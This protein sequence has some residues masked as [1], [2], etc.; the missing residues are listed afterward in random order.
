VKRRAWRG[1]LTLV[2][3]GIALTALALT[4]GSERHATTA[5]EL[6]IERDAPQQQDAER[7][8]ER[9][10]AAQVVAPATLGP[11]WIDLA[12]AAV[13]GS[14]LT[15]LI[16]AVVFFGRASLVAPAASGSA[17][18]AKDTVVQKKKG[19]GSISA[20]IANFDGICLPFGPPCAEGS[21]C[22][23]LPPDTNGDVG[24][25]QFVQMVNTDFAVY[26]KTGQ[27]LRHATPINELWSGV[28]G[29][30]FAHN[31]GDPVVVYDQFANR[32]LLSQFIVANSGEQYGQ[33]VAVSE[34]G[35]A[36]GKYFLYEFL[37]SPNVFLDYPKIG[38]WRDGYYMS[39]NEFPDGQVT[40]AG[41]AAIVFERSQM[42]NGQPA[43]FVYFDEAA[44]SYRPRA[45]RT[46]SPRSTIQRAFHP[47]DR[48]AASTCGSGGST[49][50]GRIR[51][52][53]RSG[54]TASRASRSR[55]RPSCGRS[56]STATAT[57]RSRRA[58]RR[59]STCSATA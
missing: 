47:P 7:T 42:L 53:R 5:H 40:S 48:T 23:C 41:A 45:S 10:R 6:G 54:R 52:A 27:V 43:R 57:V 12:L 24:Q 11:H 58:G 9:T 46:S 22:S 29:E 19:T 20:P 44:R 13:A 3:L 26:S 28:G 31:N 14:L 25:T 21:A 4:A 34:T 51:R 39:A 17:S 2:V 33:C 36:T 55:S 18:N 49:S 8:R 50:T 56:A 59:A 1:A 32:W 38:V 16:I 15:V 37:L 30:C 35:D